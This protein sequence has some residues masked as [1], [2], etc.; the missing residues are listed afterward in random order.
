MRVIV[1][2]DS[3]ELLMSVPAFDMRNQNLFLSLLSSLGFSVASNI[4]FVVSVRFV[5]SCFAAHAM[6]S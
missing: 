5:L 3:S 6:L 4:Q 2:S 1:Y